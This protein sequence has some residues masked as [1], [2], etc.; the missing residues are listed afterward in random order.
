MNKCRSLFTYNLIILLISLI[1]FNDNDFVNVFNDDE[2]KNYID[3]E[4][5]LRLKFSHHRFFKTFLEKFETN[6]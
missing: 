3:H 2:K 5:N 1:V 6:D 4:E